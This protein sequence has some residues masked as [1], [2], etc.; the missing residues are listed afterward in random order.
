LPDSILDLIAL[1]A[2]QVESEAVAAAAA[3]GVGVVVLTGEDHERC[4]AFESHLGALRLALR[5]LEVAYR[6][7]VGRERRAK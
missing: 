1:V 5:K 3:A 2:A 7:M 4:L 6:S